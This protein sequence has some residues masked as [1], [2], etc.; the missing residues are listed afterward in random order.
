LEPTSRVAEYDRDNMTIQMRSLLKKGIVVN[1][2][3]YGYK[4]VRRKEKDGTRR[5]DN[6]DMDNIPVFRIGP[7]NRHRPI[8]AS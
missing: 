8:I 6:G 4:C 1:V 2:I 5:R 3:D 7:I